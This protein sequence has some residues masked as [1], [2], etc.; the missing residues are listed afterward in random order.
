MYKTNNRRSKVRETKEFYNCSSF[1][2]LCYTTTGRTGSPDGSDRFTRPVGPVGTSL[3]TPP[4]RPVLRKTER[5]HTQPTSVQLDSA[6][7]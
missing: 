4:V 1:L 3:P 7:T 5:L 6:L 2:L